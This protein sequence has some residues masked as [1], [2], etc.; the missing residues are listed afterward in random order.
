[1]GIKSNFEFIHLSQRKRKFVTRKNVI[2]YEHYELTPASREV[3]RFK[4]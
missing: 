4:T 1:M 2:S 3:R